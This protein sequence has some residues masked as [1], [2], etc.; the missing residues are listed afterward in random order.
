MNVRPFRPRPNSRRPSSLRQSECASMCAAPIQTVATMYTLSEN[1]R[2]I[3]YA[4]LFV[5]NH[6]DL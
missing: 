4:L 1:L 3:V 6:L 5:R 2:S